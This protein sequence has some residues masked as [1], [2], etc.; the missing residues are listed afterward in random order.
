MT[1]RRLADDSGR[2]NFWSASKDTMNDNYYNIIILSKVTPFFLWC[3]IFHT[4]NADP[5]PIQTETMPIGVP[6]PPTADR[7]CLTIIISMNI[8]F[9]LIIL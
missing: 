5:Q 6:R 1:I 3:S 2:R 9:F 4:T 7:I 8:F